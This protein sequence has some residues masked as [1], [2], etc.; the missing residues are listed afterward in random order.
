LIFQTFYF[1]VK[2]LKTQKNIYEFLIYLNFLIL[3]FIWTAFHPLI[4]I[5]SFMTIYFIIKKNFR[6]YNIL[7]F[8][9]ILFLSS[10]P[11]IK[12]K[13]IFGISSSGWTGFYLCQTIVFKANIPECTHHI[14]SSTEYHQ[15]EYFK[16]YGK[17]REDLNHP[18]LNLGPISKRHNLGFIVASDEL[19]EKTKNF[20]IKNPE[21][22]IAQRIHAILSSHGKFSFD[23][24]I[25]PQNW[26]TNF[27]FQMKIENDEKLKLTRQII[28]FSIMMIIYFNVLFF[29]FKNNDLSQKKALFFI[30]FLY[31]YFYCLS[32]ATNGHEHERIMFTWVIVNFLSL[33]ILFK[34]LIKI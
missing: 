17:N 9:F 6:F 11:F 8:I 2:L 19:L 29:L 34:K 24:G 32:I 7:V 22:Y 15:E 25:K 1:F 31:L 10:I 30:T 26:E 12:N 28:V 23:Y 20:I 5:L 33:S 14:S 3:G 13:V 27:G 18:N 4:L 21:K 16:R